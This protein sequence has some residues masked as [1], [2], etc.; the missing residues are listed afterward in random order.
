MTVVC[1]TSPICYLILIRQ[2]DVLPQLFGQVLIPAAVRDELLAE[3]SFPEI[4]AWIVEPP[5]WLKIQD[6]S[7]GPLALPVKL[8]PSEQEAISLA[9]ELEAN[10]I[11]LDDLDARQVALEY[12]LTV[13]GLLGVLYRAAT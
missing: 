13:T 8:G 4:R 12:G 11:V 3:G 10:L 9:H 5:D 6:L 1:D 2:I 7:T